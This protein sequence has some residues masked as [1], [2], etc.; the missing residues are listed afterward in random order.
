MTITIGSHR[1]SPSQL[2]IAFGAILIAAIV[3]LAIASALV[4][5]D[6]EIGAWRAQLGNLSLTLAD[7]TAQN[8]SAAYLTLDAIAER[9]RAMELAD[10]AALRR[11]ASTS[12]VFDMMR[13]KIAGLPQADVATIVAAN[14]DVINF[15]RSFP[16]PPINLADR[17]YFQAH[18]QNPALGNFVSKSVR[19]K[20]NGKWVFYISRRVNDAHGGFIG[21]VIVGISVDAFTNFHERLGRN[22]G[23]GAAI[24]LLRDDFTLLTRWP[25]IDALIG[26][27]NTTGTT[28]TVVQTLKKTDDVIYSVVPRFSDNNQRVARLGAVRVVERFPLIVNITVTEDLFL[29]GWRRSVAVITLVAF[30]GIATLLGAL[31]FL[32]GILR[33]READ[34]V[35]TM[36][37]MRRAE[38]ASVAKSNFLATVSHEIRTPMNGVIGMAQLL[39][40]TEQTPEQQEFTAAIRSSA[41][42]L[43]AIIN[44]ILDFSKVEAKKLELENATFSPAQ[45]VR[46]IGDLFARLAA[47]KQ[48]AFKLDIADGMVEWVDGDAGR[49]RQIL[50]NLLGNAL[51]FTAAGSLGLAVA[52]E[53]PADGTVRLRFTISDSGIGIPPE[54]VDALFEPFTQLDASTTRRYGGTGLGLSIARRLA[55]LMG[56]TIAVTSTPGAGSTFTVAI[57]FALA[58]APPPPP[59][60]VV[61][62]TP[63]PSA[64]APAPHGGKVL[65]VEDNPTNQKVASAMLTRCGRQV[66]IAVNGSEALVALRQASYALILMDCQMPVMDGYE[67]TRQIR[68]GAAGETNRDVPIVAMTANA[69]VG[70]REQCL[71]VGMNDYMAKPI[72]MAELAAKL[73]Q[74][75]V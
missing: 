72:A 57:P 31:A 69:M 42:S 64:A 25:K 27:R 46:E 68:A 21:L 74:W 13:D 7:Q 3:A 10:A 20:G 50:N 9:V 48:L 61:V 58:A 70:D 17:D 4:L 75:S 39:E 12:A 73:K 34:M 49:L 45:V 43:L 30:A 6:Q 59:A 24:T 44:D 22:L 23:E 16:P 28:Y 54:R 32:V 38:E 15:T 19:N 18:A 41:V 33:R 2:T 71:A 60:A 63:A 40:R 11:R 65:L 35:Q 56:G 8:M 55:E 52:G 26:G 36:E 53:A 67:A 5:R 29:A 62:T 14:G 1:F 37:L 66:D 51:K 47:E